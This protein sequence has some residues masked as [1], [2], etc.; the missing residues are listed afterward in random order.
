VWATPE[1]VNPAPELTATKKLGE[2]NASTFEQGKHHRRDPIGLE[3][4]KVAR[5]ELKRRP[6]TK[7]IRGTKKPRRHSL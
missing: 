3:G 6:L 1:T 2:K 4:N 5:S 7:P